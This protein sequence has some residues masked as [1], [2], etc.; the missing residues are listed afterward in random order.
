MSMTDLRIRVSRIAGMALTINLL[1]AASAFASC[2]DR[3]LKY[4]MSS[5][6]EYCINNNLLDDPNGYCEG[7]VATNAK[8]NIDWVLFNNEGAR[9]TYLSAL[10][11]AEQ[12]GLKKEGW[13]EGMLSYFA[14]LRA[15]RH[16]P[17]A[18]CSVFACQQEYSAS[19]GYYMKLK[20]AGKLPQP[21][22][23]I[24]PCVPL[25]DPSLIGCK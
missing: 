7:T 20:R 3:E 10:A 22:K 15:Q 1:V 16:N 11:E 19:N 4:N 6:A 25:D 12:C 17:R 18:Q 5:W 8:K 13:G 9:Q 14:I 21:E 23:S 2:E 24:E